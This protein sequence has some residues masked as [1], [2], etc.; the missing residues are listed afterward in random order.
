M[1]SG[2]ACPVDQERLVAAAFFSDSSLLI[3]RKWSAWALRSSEVR[4]ERL[5]LSSAASCHVGR[6]GFGNEAA[7]SMEDGIYRMN[8]LIFQQFPSGIEGWLGDARGAGE[9]CGCYRVLIP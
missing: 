6:R 5:E 2:V 9:G 4:E 1:L 7:G 3:S 8:S